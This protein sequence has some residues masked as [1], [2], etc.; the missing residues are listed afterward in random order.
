MIQYWV[1]D[2]IFPDNMEG[3]SF[4]MRNEFVERNV[5]GYDSVVVV[6]T[7][8][9]RGEIDIQIQLSVYLEEGYEGQMLRLPK[10]QYEGKRS[11]GL[12]K[13]KEF[14]DAEFPIVMIE[15]GL[16]NWAGYAKSV[17]ILLPDGTTQNAG[18]R[19]SQE[20]LKEVLRDRDQYKQA[21]VRYQ[22]K[23]VDGKLR[24]PVVTALYGAERD[25]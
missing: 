5:D 12:L 24:F 9:I 15:E 10:S 25:L 19:G 18:M 8:D 6:P 11:K 20:Y 3:M 17:T 14:D 7:F 22:N 13:H 4:V 16:G 2:A 1:Y 23:T 21:T